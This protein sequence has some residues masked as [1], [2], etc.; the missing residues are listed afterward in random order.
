MLISFSII[1]MYPDFQNF[2]IS[3]TAFKLL[4]NMGMASGQNTCFMKYGVM[5]FS[6]GYAFLAVITSLH[7][8]II[9]NSFF[10]ALVAI[11]FYTHVAANWRALFTFSNKDPGLEVGI[12]QEVK[13]EGNFNYCSQCDILRHKQSHH[14]PLCHCCVLKHDHHCFFFGTCVGLNNQRFFIILCLHAALGSLYLCLKIFQTSHWTFPAW[15]LHFF[16][17]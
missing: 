11:F 17:S 5:L 3:K 13:K 2:Q 14:C 4:I 9:T 6:L 10:V 16:K 1:F 7:V 8:V 12:D 15:Y